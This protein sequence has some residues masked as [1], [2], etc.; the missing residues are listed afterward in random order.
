MI[1]GLKKEHFRWLL[2]ILRVAKPWL[3][4]ISTHLL[5]KRPQASFR[6]ETT[7]VEESSSSA[8]IVRNL[9]FSRTGQLP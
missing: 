7:F 6:F 2:L 1:S 4:F 8:N 5:T 3:I 9:C